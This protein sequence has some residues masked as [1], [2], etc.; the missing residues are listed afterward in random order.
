VDHT[1]NPNTVLSLDETFLKK[2]GD[3]LEAHFADEGFGNV[4]LAS[5]LHISESQLFRKLKALTGQ[6]TALFIRS[7]RLHKG[8]EKLENTQLTVS[9]IAYEVG[10]SDPAY[11]S[12]TFAQ[13][14]GVSPNAIRNK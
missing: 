7:Y 9:E 1:S 5:R 2:I 3:I 10:F 11:F 8:K 13:E 14:F 4:Q 6:S 12:R